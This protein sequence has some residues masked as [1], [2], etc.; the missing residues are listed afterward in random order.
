MM[1]ICNV[2]KARA[3]LYQLIAKANKTSVPVLITGKESNAVLV[4]E[5]DWKAMQET[6]YLMSIPGMTESIKR[7]REEPE[8]ELIS[9]DEVEW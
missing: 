6:L 5:S 1:E 4:S 8:D 2:S 7:G 3:N 9:A